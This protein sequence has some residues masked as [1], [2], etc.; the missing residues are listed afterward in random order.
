M[1]YDPT[2]INVFIQ[3]MPTHILLHFKPLLNH[4]FRYIYSHNNIYRKLE[5]NKLIKKLIA[6]KDENPNFIT[7]L[8]IQISINNVKYK[9]IEIP[10][11]PPIG[12][13]EALLYI[14]QN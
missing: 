12:F 10:C 2:F 9:D 4:Y 14:Q 6:F 8:E 1:Q 13:I 5:H 3:N 11:P 7:K